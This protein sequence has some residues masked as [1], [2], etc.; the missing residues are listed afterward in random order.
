MQVA[1]TGSPSRI[2]QYWFEFE[3]DLHD[4]KS[5]GGHQ[6]LLAPSQRHATLLHDVTYHR[7]D[8]QSPASRVYMLT[9]TLRS[10]P[11]ATLGCFRSLRMTDTAKDTA[12]KVVDAT[13]VGRLQD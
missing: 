5:E 10:I 7:H 6:D 4:D 9:I 12:H 1:S 3:W 13:Q 8:A 2:V 11:Q